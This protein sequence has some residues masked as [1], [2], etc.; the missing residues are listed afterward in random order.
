VLRDKISDHAI[1]MDEGPGI[2][3]GERDARD[4]V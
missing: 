2:H 4:S 1:E 3:L